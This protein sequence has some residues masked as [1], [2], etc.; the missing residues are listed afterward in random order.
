MSKNFGLEAS[1]HP[2]AQK[3]VNGGQKTATDIP[4]AEY[5]RWPDEH[6][7]RKKVVS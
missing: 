4:P 3:V 2:A 1:L 5:E 6:S 7:Q